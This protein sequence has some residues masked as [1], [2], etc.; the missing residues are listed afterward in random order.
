MVRLL[1]PRGRWFLLK[2]VPLKVHSLGGPRFGHSHN[3]NPPQDRSAP[4]SCFRR[5]LKLSYR[6]DSKLRTR[7]ALG[8][9]GRPMPRS[10][11]PPW[12]RHVFLISSDPCTP[13]ILVLA[14]HMPLLLPPPVFDC[15]DGYLAHKK[16][17]PPPRTTL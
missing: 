15:R 3:Q 9:Y 5:T 16:Q 6:G 17:L 8:S 4:R 1:G 7:A 13:P 14:T 12:G 2:E 11:G 10:K